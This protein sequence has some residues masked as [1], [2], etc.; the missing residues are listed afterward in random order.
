MEAAQQF[1]PNFVGLQLATGERR[2]YIIGCYL[3]P[4]YNLMIESVVTALKERPWVDELLVAGE[5]DVNLE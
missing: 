4:N 2:W 1:G 3:A 5:L